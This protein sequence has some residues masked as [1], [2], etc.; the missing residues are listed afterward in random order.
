V[1]LPGFEVQKII[2]YDNAQDTSGVIAAVYVRY[3]SNVSSQ[4]RQI[5]GLLQCLGDIG[6][7]QG[8]LM[9]IGIYFVQFIQRKQ[10]IAHLV[11]SMYQVKKH[12][13]LDK[14]KNDR[15]NRKG[16]KQNNESS[17]LSLKATNKSIMEMN[18]PVQVYPT[19]AFDIEAKGH[20]NGINTEMVKKNK[21]YEKIDD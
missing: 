20:N 19:S 2:T 17:Q 7:L 5:Y 21:T 1:D 14:I 15:K 4:S 13:I 6:G 10:Y 18:T 16:G 8:C 12:K 9:M 11:K 3:D